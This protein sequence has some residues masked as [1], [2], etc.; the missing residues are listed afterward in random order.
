MNDV[1]ICENCGNQNEIMNL[2]CTKCGFD[3]SFIIPTQQKNAAEKKWILL[4]N[5]NESCVEFPIL[6]DAE[7]GRNG[8]LA[9]KILD[10]SDFTS[11]SHAR[12][13]FENEKLFLE[14]FSRNGTFLNGVRIPKMT[15]TSLKSND[16][17]IFAD[18]KFILKGDSNAD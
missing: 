10:T 2:E 17:I 11:R 8:T 5:N 4:Y 1:R 7:I 9:E 14:D 15:K 18:I 6:G 16:E 12:I 3:L 13:F